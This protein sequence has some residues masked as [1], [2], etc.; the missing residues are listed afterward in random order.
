VGHAVRANY[1]YAG[2]ADLYL[3]TGDPR[4]L[5]TLEACWR[6][7]QLK[8]IYITGGCGALYDGASPDGSDQQSTITRTHQA[9]GRNYQLPNS[10]AHN[11]TCAAIGNVLWNYRMW[12]ISDQPKYIDAL[13]NSL[14]NAVLAGVSLDGKRFFYTNTLRQLNSMPT[15][16]RW[17]R[18]R[19]EWISCYC[20]PPNVARTIASVGR[21]AYSVAPDVAS[22]LLYGS[23]DLDTKLSDGSR[24]AIS[25]SSNYPY[26]GRV[27]LVIRAA[28]ARVYSLRLRIPGWCQQATLLVNGVEQP[29]DSVTASFN[30]VT[31]IWQPGDRIELT[32][33]LPVQLMAAHSLVEECAGQVAVQRGPLIYCLESCDL[34]PQTDLLSAMIPGSSQWRMGDEL[35]SWQFVRT[36][37][38]EL[39]LDA[40]PAHEVAQPLY[41]VYHGSKS[42]RFEGSLV[43]YFAWGNRGQSEMSVWISVQPWLIE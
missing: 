23:N 38:S 42:K 12:R 31:R 1:L 6:N 24:L 11:E 39:W 21:Y 2:A 13:E 26:D 35:G 28:P 10:T 25:Q 40:T 29:V 14:Y 8:K 19:Q 30:E 36:L 16:L 17:S 33:D 4:L 7:V 43:P 37:Q 20:C 18:E 27:Q 32:M 15:D 9:Y 22:V 5:T 3:E 41:R 34:P